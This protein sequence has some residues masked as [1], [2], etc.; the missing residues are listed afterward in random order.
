LNVCRTLELEVGN[1]V[2]EL[3]C[4]AAHPA[5]GLLL[6]GFQDKLRLYTVLED[7]LKW[8]ASL[9][10]RIVHMSMCAEVFGAD[11]ALKLATVVD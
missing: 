2:E 11:A 10:N 3:H 8:V 7:E 5:A 6:V 1:F 4:V 9:G